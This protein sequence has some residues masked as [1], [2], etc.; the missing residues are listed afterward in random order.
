MCLLDKV[1]QRLVV[2]GQQSKMFIVNAE[3]GEVLETV[4]YV[5]DP[6][7]TSDVS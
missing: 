2:A 1:S 3:I 5:I 7:S 4:S 6:K